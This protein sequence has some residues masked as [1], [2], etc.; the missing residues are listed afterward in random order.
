MEILKEQMLDLVKQHFRYVEIV[1]NDMVTEEC[2]HLINKPNT[3]LLILGHKNNRHLIEFDPNDKGEM[4]D[5]IITYG[6]G[7]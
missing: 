7:K 5:I 1:P 2:K 4:L 6:V 3:S